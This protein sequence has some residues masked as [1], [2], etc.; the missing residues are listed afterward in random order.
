MPA[1]PDP[2]IF[3]RDDLPAESVWILVPATDVFQAVSC[4]SWNQGSVLTS[5]SGPVPGIGLPC[6]SGARNFISQLT[7]VSHFEPL[8]LLIPFFAGDGTQDCT[9][10]RQ[11]SIQP[12]KYTPTSVC[13]FLGVQ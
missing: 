2:I 5:F 1:L 3:G 6:D 4:A 7:G 8:F 9:H 12:R 11:A 13:T 10:A